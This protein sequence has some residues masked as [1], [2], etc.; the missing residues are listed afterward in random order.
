MKKDELLPA[1]MSVAAFCAWANIGRTT[2]YHEIGSGRLEARK[3]GRRTIITREAAE[4]WLRS[5]P[6]I[7]R[8]GRID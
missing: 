2:A 3:C 5:L 8:I 1:A 7:E 4:R 6:L